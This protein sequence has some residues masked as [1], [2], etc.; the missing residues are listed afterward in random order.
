MLRQEYVGES[1]TRDTS[2]VDAAVRD[3][4]SRSLGR[5]HDRIHRT[6]ARLLEARGAAGTL[7]D[8][9]CGNGDLWRVVSPRFAACVGVDAVRYP[10]LPDD[11]RF[12]PADLDRA[13]P[14]ADASVDAAAAIEVVEHLENPRAFVRE[15]A[16]VTRP[17]GWIVVTTPNQLSLLSLLCLMRKGVFGA[18]QDGD[19]PAH[20]TALL[21]IDLR[22]IA[23]EC[24]LQQVAVEYTRWGRVP[25]TPWH[26]PAACAALAPRRLSDNVALVGRC[27]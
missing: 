19:Y 20:R 4:A 7:L 21:E 8:A 15:L 5:A 23:A 1:V 27:G 22:R 13:L 11:V 9:G 3:R 12:E 17:G 24:G 2:A 14:L 18:F 25:L 6:A 26:Y 16:R 10:G